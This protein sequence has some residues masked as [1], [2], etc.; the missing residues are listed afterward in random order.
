MNRSKHQK[1]A[2]YLSLMELGQN[3]DFELTGS[4]AGFIQKIHAIRNKCLRDFTAD[5]I[6]VCLAQDIG[7]SYLLPKALDLLEH[8]P[9]I[10]AE[11]YEG[12][13]LNVCIDV[14]GECWN[15][16]KTARSR[17]LKILGAANDLIKEGLFTAGRQEIR[18][19]E[20]G[21]RRFGIGAEQ[22]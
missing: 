12:D 13:L 21:F 22:E 8:N 3:S 4:E 18:D 7:T 20:R 10:E 19:L 9:W 14:E 16:L 11:H 15:I 5:E 17:M 6:R 1:S 2:D